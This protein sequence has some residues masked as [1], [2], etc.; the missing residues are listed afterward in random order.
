[1]RAVVCHAIGEPEGLA[2]EDID[3][4]ALGPGE[5]RIAVHA[6]SINY[7]DVLMVQGLYQ[8]RADL[9]FV[10]GT[11]A[12]GVVAE[13]APDVQGLVPGHR[14]MAYAWTGAFAEEMVVP[15]INAY[16]L[17]ETIDFAAAA[18]LKS[19]YGTAVYA[20][21]E[22]ARLAP[23]ETVVVHGAAGGVGLAMVEVA[24]LLGGRVI[25]TVGAA[26]KAQLVRDYG[27]EAVIVTAE[28]DVRERVLELTGGRGADVICDPVGGDL[29]EA[30]VRC[31][32]W[33]GGRLLVLG[34][35]SG[36]IP[37]LRVNQLLLKS[38]DLVGV[39]FGGWADREPA[40]HRALMEPIVDWCAA[41]RVRPHVSRTWPLAEAGAAMRSLLDR[42]ATGKVILQV[43]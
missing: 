5:V 32:A 16:A 14:V 43:R 12:A 31:I 33:G 3:P 19:V 30:S 23:G 28:E 24:R 4:P 10:P 2:L 26:G 1:M 39:N 40:A 27:A 8:R 34:F 7:F 41:G 20:L 15:A 42:S 9:P 17:P 6:A 25:G 37:E 21:R 35:T 22:R 11:D 18:A 13:V 29:F 36:R 38:F